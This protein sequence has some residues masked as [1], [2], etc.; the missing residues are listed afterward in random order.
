MNGR[1]MRRF[2]ALHVLALI[3]ATLMVGRPALVSAQDDPTELSQLPGVQSGVSRDWMIPFSWSTPEPVDG[4]QI[5]Y[6]G[7]SIV[8]FDTEAHAQESFGIIVKS[9]AE[10]PADEATPDELLFAPAD[11]GSD[12]GDERAAFQP[13]DTA[14]APISTLIVR[15]GSLIYL[16]VG[17]A[18]QGDASEAVATLAGTIIDREAGS[19]EG[20]LV[21]DGTS[22]G[23]LW[24]KFP[25]SDDPVLAGLTE[26]SDTDPLVEDSAA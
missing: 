20:T 1:T 11:F 5:G 6:L 3:L 23:G 4:P 26:V 12:L 13:A 22:S 19:G 25:P 21:D 7:A 14:W 18:M 15:D 2:G 24:D 16:V 9:L 10:T 17:T 8:Q